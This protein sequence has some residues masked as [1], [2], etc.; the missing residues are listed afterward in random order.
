MHLLQALSK[1]RRALKTPVA[2]PHLDPLPLQQRPQ[3]LLGVGEQR[4][5]RVLQLTQIDQDLRASERGGSE[6]KGGGP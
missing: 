5:R 1:P 4:A 2:P 6:H 3:L